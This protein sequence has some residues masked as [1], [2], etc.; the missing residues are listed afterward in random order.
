MTLIVQV[1]EA[2]DDVTIIAMLWRATVHAARQTDD[3]VE[4]ATLQSI[5]RQ[6]QEMLPE[7]PQ[8]LEPPYDDCNRAGRTGANFNF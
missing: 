6:L 5:N 7:I 4:A 2:L 3:L 8:A 1:S